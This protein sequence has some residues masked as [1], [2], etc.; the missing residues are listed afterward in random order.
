MTG[1]QAERLPPTQRYNRLMSA[2]E[3]WP[4]VDPQ[5]RWATD[6]MDE[7]LQTT[8]QTPEEL[9]ARAHDLRAKAA[10][11]DIDGFRSGYLKVANRY[12]QT[13]AARLASH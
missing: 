8:T 11:T 2:A 1:R 5:A 4:D 12:E 7:L 9:L 10:A 13:A 3:N 6:L